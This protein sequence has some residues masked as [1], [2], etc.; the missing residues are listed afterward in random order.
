MQRR[1]M[2]RSA[3]VIIVLL[4]V[5]VLVGGATRPVVPGLLPDTTAT[6]A[7]PTSSANGTYL[8]LGDSL[9]FGAR[10]ES[11]GTNPNFADPTSFI[12]YP[13]KVAVDRQVR[14]L[15]AAVPGE[16]TESFMGAFTAQYRRDHPLHV[17]YGGAP[18]QFTYAQQVLA[19]DPTV[20][21]VT[22]QLGAN[23]FFACQAQTADN[24]SSR[25]EVT[26]V[27]Q[28]VQANL[29]TILKALRAT[30]YGGLVVVV[31]YYAPDYADGQTAAAVQALNAAIAAVALPQGARVADG[32]AAFRAPAMAAGG[33]PTAAGLVLP[34]D[35]HPT[36]RGQ[37]L[38]ADAV[39][40]VLS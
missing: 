32:Y 6:P 19:S 37:R 7:P 25:A 15:N 29:T 33:S 1:A 36:D 26:R 31:S 16:T 8:A 39:E 18:S 13:Q 5:F 22:L 9:P 38:L 4:A 10:D 27:A 24:C 30:G 2:A 3:G 23:D 14:L 11:S 34:N 21:L 20:N 12:G 40:A 35:V 28:Q 17:E